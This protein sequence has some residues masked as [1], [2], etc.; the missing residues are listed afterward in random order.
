MIFVRIDEYLELE[1]LSF[2]AFPAI[3]VRNLVIVKLSEQR[4]IVV[5]CE[6]KLCMIGHCVCS[7]RSKTLSM[8]GPVLATIR[9]MIF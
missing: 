9:I 1:E 4:R 7:L 2:F 8:C 5:E 3:F 6:I